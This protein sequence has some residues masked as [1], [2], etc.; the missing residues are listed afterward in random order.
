MWSWSELAR[1]EAARS[2]GELSSL[3]M[4]RYFVYAG[5]MIARIQEYARRTGGRPVPQTP[6]GEL[7]GKPTTSASLALQ[8]AAAL[9]MCLL[10]AADCSMPAIQYCRWRCTERSLIANDCRRSWP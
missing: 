4:H 1:Q 6:A 5:G 7:A 10:S 3:W 8:Y 2:F 9:Q